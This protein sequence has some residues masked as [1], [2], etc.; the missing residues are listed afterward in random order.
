[1]STCCTHVHAQLSPAFIEDRMPMKQRLTLQT[2]SDSLLTIDLRIA[3]TAC[4]HA[5]GRRAAPAGAA[6]EDGG[7]LSSQDGIEDGDVAVR[8]LS[9]AAEVPRDEDFEAD[10]AALME[11]HQASTYH[12]AQCYVT[13]HPNPANCCL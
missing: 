8:L 10:F 2:E 4:G 3:T 11:T 5:D 6:A 7:S 13:M 1:M 9:P 12:N